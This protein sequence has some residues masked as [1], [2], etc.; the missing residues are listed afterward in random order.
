[1]NTEHT[2]TISEVKRDFSKAALLAETN[3]SAVITENNRPKY[4]LVNLSRNP[5][6]D[7]TDDERMDLAAKRVLERYR[8][9][10]EILAK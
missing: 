8:S 9:A 5:I 1:M 10:F 6:F 4:A 3:G 2:L 7:L